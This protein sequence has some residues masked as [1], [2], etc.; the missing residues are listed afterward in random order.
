MYIFNVFLCGFVVNYS[1]NVDN[2][3]DK[4]KFDCG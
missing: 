1:H 4:F 3:V 2:Y